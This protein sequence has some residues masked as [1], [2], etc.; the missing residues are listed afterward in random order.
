M[1]ARW[2]AAAILLAAC[3]GEQHA[4]VTVPPHNPGP[5]ADTWLGHGSTWHQ[6]TGA[7]PSPRY[8]AS[9]AYDA[10]R[11]NYVLFGGQSGSVS[12]DDTW[13]FDGRAWRRVLPAH[14]PSP[15]RDAAMAY[16]PSLQSVVLYGGLIANAAEGVEAADTW[17][18]DGSDWKE[19]SGDNN[20]PHFRYG[21]GM[22]TAATHVIL[23]GGHIF[24]TRYFGDAWTLAGT[25]W[26]RLDYGPSPAGRGNAAVAWNDDDSSLFVFGGLGMREGAGPGNLGVPLMDAWSLKAGAWS[27]TSA[28]PPALYDA[29]A[30]WDSAA[31][32]VFVILGMNCPQPVNDAWAWNGSA[33]TRSTLPVPARWA[34][35]AASDPSG[36]VLVFGGDDETGC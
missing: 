11:A 32:S 17:T 6:V 20:G 7:H 13:I 35:S 33:W 23:F 29:S 19:V 14:R 9:L 24:N 30:V 4:A 27:K 22:V 25:T 21:A 18:W 3:G 1:L 31:H 36:N 15:R 34:A 8:A 12:Y 16:D 2:L 5:L 26:V 10:A 28:G